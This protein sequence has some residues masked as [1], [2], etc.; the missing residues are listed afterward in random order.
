MFDYTTTSSFQRTSP[1]TTTYNPRHIDRARQSIPTL[2]RALRCSQDSSTSHPNPIHVS[3]CRPLAIHPT[4]SSSPMPS[5]PI[6]IYHP[7]QPTTPPAM[8]TSASANSPQ[9]YSPQTPL[10]RN[11]QLGGM[12]QSPPKSL[13][14]PLGKGSPPV[15]A[16][17]PLSPGASSGN[18]FKWAAASLG[19]SP[20]AT[21]PLASNGGMSIPQ[22]GQDDH[23]GDHALENHDS[24][25]FGDLDDL[26]SR[27]WATGRRAA[28][29]SQPS[30]RQSGI[31]S[32]LT[33][34]GA[35]PMETSSGSSILAD[36]AAKG[37][38]I[39]RR[40]S[41]SGSFP[42]VSFAVDT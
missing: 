41:I 34:F 32:M 25:E 39:M 3:H 27:S 4:P 30:G 36:N 20:T 24:F 17:G 38:G 11:T 2:T 42:R 18:F 28:S 33:G 22:S 7:I 16:L 8:S 21:N 6:P 9:S 40:L 14:I 15:S 35:S 31:S 19:K 26:K 12:P 29:M 37:Q 5:S 10:D 23:H 1:I 13:P